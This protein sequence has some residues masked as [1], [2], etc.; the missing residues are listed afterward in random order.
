MAS[1]ASA[2]VPRAAYSVSGDERDKDKVST[3]AGANLARCFH[4]SRESRARAR[5][6][7]AGT[8]DAAL[9]C[10]TLPAVAKDISC[11]QGK[12]TGNKVQEAGE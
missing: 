6:R 9:L 8:G 11:T 4:T 1:R 5:C 3:G 12:R 7:L 2:K 10:P